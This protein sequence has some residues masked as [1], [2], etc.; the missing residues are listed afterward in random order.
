MGLIEKLVIGVNVERGAD[1]AGDGSAGSGFGR[2]ERRRREE[3]RRQEQER[4]QAEERRRERE[5]WEENRRRRQENVG[6]VVK[7]TATG[8]FA[9]IALSLILFALV[10]LDETTRLIVVAGVIGVAVLVV[11]ARGKAEARDAEARKEEARAKATE[12]ILKTPLERLSEDDE[13]EGLDDLEEKYAEAAGVEVPKKTRGSASAPSK[14]AGH[15][16]RCGTPLEYK[17]QEY[18]HHCGAKFVTTVHVDKQPGA[19]RGPTAAGPGPQSPDSS[20]N[21]QDINSV[22]YS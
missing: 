13:F 3:E 16:S 2:N 4:R 21:S 14:G 22:Q 7:W 11:D 8:L 5:R 15:C 1:K 12:R 18:C 19:G 20:L 17:G 10:F 9:I 6:N